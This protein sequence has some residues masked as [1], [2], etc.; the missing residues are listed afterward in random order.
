VRR[1]LLTQRAWIDGLRALCYTNAAALDLGRRELADLLIPLSKGLATDVC[2]ELTSLAVQVHGGMGYVEETGVAQ[3]YRAARITAIYEGNNGI[4]AADLVGRKLGMR[5]GGAV[6][7]LLAEFELRAKELSAV[8]GLERFGD[9]LAAAVGWAREASLHLGA[10]AATDPRSLLAG[11]SPYLRLLGT[12]VVAGLLAK[13]ALAATELG[14]ADKVVSARFFGEQILPTV[15][16][17][18]PAIT[19]DAAILYDFQP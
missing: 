12:T 1:M 13:Q 14:L 5:G 18:L 2:N 9:Q 8:A 3:H 17:L 4:Q 19:A 7:D 6:A 15:Q 11:S 16:G 10:V